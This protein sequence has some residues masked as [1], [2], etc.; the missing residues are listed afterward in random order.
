MTPAMAFVST[1]HS[2]FIGSPLSSS[3]CNRRVTTSRY[4]KP[5]G[6][7]PA[8]VVHCELADLATPAD[9]SNDDRPPITDAEKEES[10]VEEISVPESASNSE[11][12]VDL[13]GDN[14]PT[15]AVEVSEEETEAIAEEVEEGMEAVGKNE[16]KRRRP[17]RH[18]KREVTVQ[19]EDLTVGQELEGTVRSVTTY[20][21]FVGDLGT[22]TD[23]LLH[24]SQ[25]SNSFV[26]NVTDIV[27]V[28]DKLTV[29]V[30]NVDL[31]K[32]NLSLTLKT[33]KA[34]E[35]PVEGG[36]TRK[37]GERFV[38]A[39]KNVRASPKSNRQSGSE[40][41][42]N[43]QFDP[44]KFIDVKIVNLTNF[45]AFCKLL[46]EEGNANESAPTD[47][48]IHV[49]EIQDGRVDNI[50]KELSVGQVV[51]ARVIA[52]DRNRNRI[53]LSLKEEKPDERSSLEEDMAANIANQ[54]VFKTTF[55]LAFERARAKAGK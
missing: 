31:E 45:G 19:L 34:A 50:E 2:S 43:F 8:R 11:E 55:E 28:G 44:S 4:T 17:R 5:C 14:E 36:D 30:L 48:L 49:S 7:A 51:K 53:S 9:D 16:G 27:N 25:L 1:I 29:R 41:W 37:Q 3:L 42:K 6:R 13:V 32:G 23:G 33:P 40:R 15:A 52:V 10:S 21:A 47:G 38:G 24:V 26:E 35:V 20:G 12:V 22:P 39:R 54:P 46:D 18:A